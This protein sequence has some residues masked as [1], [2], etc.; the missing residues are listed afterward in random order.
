MIL[1]IHRKPSSN[2]ALKNKRFVRGKYPYGLLLGLF[3]FLLYDVTLVRA[4]FSLLLSKNEFL[5][6]GWLISSVCLYFGFPLEFL[7]NWRCSF[8]F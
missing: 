7:L 3:F 2:K 8:P 4:K 1:T 6:R 5:A